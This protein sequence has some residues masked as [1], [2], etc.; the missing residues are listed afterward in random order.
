MTKKLVAR[1]AALVLL[2]GGILGATS[3]LEVPAVSAES[4]ESLRA[5][6][7]ALE[8]QMAQITASITKPA[9]IEAKSFALTDDAENRRAAIEMG[10]AGPRI[11]IMD[12]NQRVRV[13][14]E[15]SDKSGNTFIAMNA[16]DGQPRMMLTATATGQGGIGLGG[17]NGIPRIALS[18]R[19]DDMPMFSMANARGQSCIRIV[20]DEKDIPSISLSDRRDSPRLVMSLLQSGFPAIILTDEQGK[21]VFATPRD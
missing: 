9:A 1:K 7:E 3:A 13:C 17:S 10:P 15:Y 8:S 21:I 5:R 2:F 11:V 19:D 14:L 12:A 18:V 16:K 6:V 4:I 20:C